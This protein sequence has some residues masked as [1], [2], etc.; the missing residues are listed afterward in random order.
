MDT[1]E[2]KEAFMAKYNILVRVEINHCHSG[3]W[4][5]KRPIGA[6]VIPMI[7]FIKDGMKIP[8][9]KVVRGFLILYRL[10]TTQCSLNLFWILGSVDSLNEKMGINLSHH[11]VNWVYSCQNSKEIGMDEAWM[12]IS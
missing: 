1:P 6:V 8:I 12:R 4:Y 2:S 10:C 5:T 3:K 7:V 11:N 9:G